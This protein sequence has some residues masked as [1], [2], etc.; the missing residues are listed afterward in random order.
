MIIQL[1][2]IAVLISFTPGV[3]RAADAAPRS[4]SPSE[5]RPGEPTPPNT[6]PAPP[7]STIDPGIQKL[8]ETVPD[9]KAA[10]PPPVVDPNMVIDPETRRRES[11]EVPQKDKPAAPPGAPRR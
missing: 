6:M 11:E 1:L 9:P 10:V 4:D 7:P 8:P 2:G 5:S 3:A